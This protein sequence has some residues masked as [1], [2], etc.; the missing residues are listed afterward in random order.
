MLPANS[1]GARRT[2]SGDCEL[3]SGAPGS[4]DCLDIHP[5]GD[6]HNAQRARD[7]SA[8]AGSWAMRM[9]VFRFTPVALAIA[10]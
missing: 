5:V 2:A 3:D 7:A 6:D 1:E 9:T 4:W 10:E 8:L